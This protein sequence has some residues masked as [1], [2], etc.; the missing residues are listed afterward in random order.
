MHEPLAQLLAQQ[1]PRLVA[2]LARALGIEHWALAEDAVQQASLQ[3]LAHW[4]ASGVP[5]NA[6]G[7]LYRVA[8]RQALDV[9]RHDSR[10]EALPDDEAP[11]PLT[12]LAPQARLAG[13]LDDDELALLFAAC[14][15]VLPPASQ[16]AL[17][18]RAGTPLELAA[19]AEGLLVSEAALA[20]RLARARVLLRGV[21]LRLPAGAELAPR[22][23][24]VLVALQLMFTSGMKA[25]GRCGERE[26]PANASAMALCWEAV[27]LARALAAHP[28]T[29]SA[30]ADALA[31]LLLLHG[32]RLS[33]RLDERG[34]M[35]PLSGQPRD[36]WDGS[37]VRLGLQHLR[38]AQRGGA[39]TRWH[40]LAGIAAEHALAADWAHT[41]W[42]T[43]AGYYETL[44]LLDP[45]PAPRLGH[46]IAL[47]AGG[48]AARALA[49]LHELL[50]EVPRALEAHTLAALADAH[51]RLGQHA[52]A[53][54]RWR[55]AILAVQHAADARMLEQ[56]LHRGIAAR[57]SATLAQPQTPQG[58]PCDT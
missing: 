1:R 45:S 58:Q 43:I 48:D 4:P 15:P 35:I 51:A 34:E 46:A 7:W 16:V 3:A 21:D 33:G 24:A 36:R 55:Q 49:L 40:L 17:A 41:D 9:L 10:H 39:L 23:E 53:E 5:A 57:T 29:A 47:A 38:A 19:I 11:A 32:A 44:L 2:H 8:W 13:E 6:A 52:D 28:C 18:L 14:H 12:V 37:L 31:A 50:P 27:R 56:R 30:E 20:Q 26:G 42:A 54:A 25:A 22:R